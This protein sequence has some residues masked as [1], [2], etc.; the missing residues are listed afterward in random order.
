MPQVAGIDSSTQACTIVLRD[1]DDGRVVAMAEAPH[2]RA[3][4]PA[5]EQDPQAWWEALCT[6]AR[7][8]DLR[9]VS[10]VSVDAQGHGLVALDAARRV[11]RPA[12]LW[13]DTTAAAE[14]QELVARLGAVE[15]ARR[16]GIVPVSAITIAKLLWFARHE[17]ANFERLAAIALPSDY[18]TLRLTGNLVT[19]RSEGSGTGYLSAATSTW[20]LGLLALVDARVDWLGRLP[21]VAAPHEPAGTITREASEVTGLPYGI[22][23]GPGAN[24]Q[25]VSALSLGTVDRDVVISLGTSGTVSARSRVPVVDPTGTVT[26]VADAT[27]AYLPLA[28]TLNATR[29]TDAF[30]RVLGVDYEMLA[31]LALAAPGDPDRPI[32]IPYLDGERTPNR[33]DA[34]GSLLGLRSDVCREQVAR[35]AFEGVLCG[36][37]DGLDVIRS[38]GVPTDGRLVLTGGGSHSPAYRQ[39]L[40][41]LTG[42]PVCTS[43][44]GETSA[45]GAAVQAAAVLRN[46]PVEDVA[47]AWAP[48]LRIAAEPRHGQRSAELRARYRRLAAVEDL[49]EAN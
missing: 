6:A 41:D 44:L 28:C 22:P 35:A 21:H 4:P 42:R 7:R 8:L 3:T 14:A 2:P 46:V 29:V 19:D 30:A 27:G 38:L 15:W 11:I 17:P 34:R 9:H 1:A 23:V 45:S 37:L 39:L 16:T 43:D 18:L 32:V 40:A 31:E 36:L 33:P 48:E 12:K 13:N 49:D 10:A 47:R 24:D 5:S 20:D 26:G 25:P